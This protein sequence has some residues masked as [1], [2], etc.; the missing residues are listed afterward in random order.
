MQTEVGVPRATHRGS[1]GAPQ[2]RRRR[3]APGVIGVSGARRAV[4]GVLGQVA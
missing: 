4:I 1:V 3:D 2:C